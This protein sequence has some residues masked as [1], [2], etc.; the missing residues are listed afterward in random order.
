MITDYAPPKLSSLTLP[1][2][3]RWSEIFGEERPLIVEIGFGYGH[4]LEHLARLHPDKNIIGLEISSHC[5]VKMEQAIPR[6]GLHNVRVIFSTAETALHH[7]FEPES[8]TEFHINFPDP[9]F[10]KRHA[11]RRLV[12]RDTLDAVVSRLVPGGMLYLATDIRDYAEMSAELLADAPGLTNA[13]NAP[14]VHT[15]PGR[16]TTKYEKKARQEGRICH[17]F[18]YRR[19][20]SAAPFVPVIKDLEM[21][22]IVFK[23]P[24]SLDDLLAIDTP[25]DYAADQMNIRFM[26]VYSGRNSLLYEVFIH[27]ATIDQHIALV[28]VTRDDK[29]GEYTLKLSALGNPRPTEGIHRAVALLGDS[30]VAQ[31]SQS[32][33]IHRK[34]REIGETSA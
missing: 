7:L 1:W 19:N 3:A 13:L 31:H 30:L 27:E 25:A 10:K 2:P 4:F 26:H 24:L 14:W 5:L 11:G 18:A 8:V 29:P 22:H 12:Q 20:D 16:Q 23:T 6:K 15:M 33:F 9:W 28:L 21:P 34:V 17:Y 32:E